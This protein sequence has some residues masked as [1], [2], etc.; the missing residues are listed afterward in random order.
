MGFAYGREGTKHR[1]MQEQRV[2]KREHLRR[3]LVLGEGGRVKKSLLPTRMDRL[4]FDR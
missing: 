2:P 3:G 1:E 4:G